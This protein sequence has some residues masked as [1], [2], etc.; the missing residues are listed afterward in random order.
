METG[1]LKRQ[2][3]VRLLRDAGAT[4]EGM[5]LRGR[6]M[7]LAVEAQGYY[8]DEYVEQRKCAEPGCTIVHGG[9]SGT[10]ARVRCQEHPAPGAV[11]RLRARLDRLRS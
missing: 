2:L 6:L 1:D 8:R 3:E 11:E 7:R 10:R 5:I 9:Y 4:P